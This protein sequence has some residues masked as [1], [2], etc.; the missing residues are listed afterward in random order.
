MT[1]RSPN[2]VSKTGWLPQQLTTHNIYLKA[3][4]TITTNN[5]DYQQ[6]CAYQ[7]VKNILY[8]IFWQSVDLKTEQHKCCIFIKKQNA[9]HTDLITCTQTTV[10][11]STQL[12]LL[13][14]YKN[15][16]ATAN[17]VNIKC[18]L[19]TRTYSTHIQ[20]YMKL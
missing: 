17:T 20:T 12:C 5:A 7:L 16:P 13:V 18:I 15:N 4:R 6:L 11:D 14:T 9:I 2:Q 8:T 1:G 19:Y 10:F 3:Q